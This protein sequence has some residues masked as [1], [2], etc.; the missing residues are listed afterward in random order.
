M[1][2]GAA[3]L[4]VSFAVPV[5]GCQS[6]SFPPPIT[7]TSDSDT[8]QGEPYDEPVYDCDPAALQACDAGEK[9][10]ALD[11][12]GVR[13]YYACVA[14]PDVTKMPYE[15]CEVEAATGIDGCPTGHAC[16]APAEDLVAGYCL[17]L[18]GKYDSSCD[19]ICVD[20]PYTGERICTPTCGP[21]DLNCP[22]ELQC[23]PHTDERFSCRYAGDDYGGVP[24]D[25]CDT[26]TKQGCRETLACVQGNLVPDCQ[27]QACCTPLCETDVPSDM[28]ACTLPAECVPF[29]ETS[30]PP[31]L[32]D[33]GACVVTP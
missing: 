16:I 18:C 6:V 3:L 19:G 21:L 32:Q 17:P 4:L 22:V 12:N 15:S 23:L 14:D 13:N 10:T 24:G 33:V 11:Y 25:P 1:R 31:E 20:G 9:C 5:A 27:E 7:E 2:A 29:V 8:G 26:Y 30:P 28:N